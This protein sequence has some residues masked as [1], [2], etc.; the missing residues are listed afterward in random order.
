MFAFPPGSGWSYPTWLTSAIRCWRFPV[1]LFVCRSPTTSICAWRSCCFSAQVSEGSTSPH[2]GNFLLLLTL[3]VAL[4]PDSSCSAKRRLKEPGGVWRHPHVLHQGAGESHREARTELQPEL[5][6]FLSAHQ[7]AGFHAWGTEAEHVMQ[8][9]LFL[10][11]Q[12]N[13]QRMVINSPEF[14]WSMDNI[15]HWVSCFPLCVC[16]WSVGFS[17]SASTPLWISPWV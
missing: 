16:R 6:A 14:A 9:K 3:E 7:A 1:S 4:L 11:H 15:W 5:A 8:T 12:P 13:R 2:P 10:H 17:A